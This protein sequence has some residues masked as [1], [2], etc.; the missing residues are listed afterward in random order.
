MKYNINF[1]NKP[2]DKEIEILCKGLEQ[3]AKQTIGKTSFEPFGFL[4]HNDSEKLIGGCTGELVYGTLYIKFLWVEKL[5]RGK[6][7]GRK[8]IEKAENFAKENNCC[9]I[10]LH[11]FNWQAKEFYEKMG[12]NTEFIYDGYDDNFQLYFFRKRLG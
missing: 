3:H 12:Y 1:T 7:I 5:E 8:L 11:T 9:N 2:S 10:T 4:V 6:G